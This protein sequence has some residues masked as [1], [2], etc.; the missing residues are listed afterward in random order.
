MK[1]N[2]SERSIIHHVD[3]GDILKLYKKPKNKFLYKGDTEY[4]ACCWF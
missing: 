2:I 1:I 3:K 4:I